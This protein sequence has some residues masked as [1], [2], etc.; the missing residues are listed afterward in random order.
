[1]SCL[2]HLKWTF[3]Q[4][5]WA[6]RS[7]RRRTCNQVFAPAPNAGPLVKIRLILGPSEAQRLRLI[8][9]LLEDFQHVVKKM[10][11]VLPKEAASI[12]IIAYH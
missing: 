8:H 7:L 6:P 12:W 2:E 9:H 5:L 10:N 11:D 3:L 4:C 1:M